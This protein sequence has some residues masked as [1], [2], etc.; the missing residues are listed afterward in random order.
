LTPSPPCYFVFNISNAF[1]ASLLNQRCLNIFSPKV[2]TV[3]NII[4][5]NEH[6]KTP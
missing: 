6:T 5:L 4:N 2:G 1:L 3:F